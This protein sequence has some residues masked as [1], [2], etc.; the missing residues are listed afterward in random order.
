MLEYPVVEV[1]P[2]PLAHEEEPEYML[3]SGPLPG[4]Q[5]TG[6]LEGPAASKDPASA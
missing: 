5:Y 3:V 1:E 6:G 2:Y 4:S